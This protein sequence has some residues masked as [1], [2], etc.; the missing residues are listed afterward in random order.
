MATRDL[1]HSLKMAGCRPSGLGQYRPRIQC[2]RSIPTPEVSEACRE[3]SGSTSITKRKVE[4]G[5][6]ELR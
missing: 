5:R 2:P 4:R 3:S 1:P 6:G